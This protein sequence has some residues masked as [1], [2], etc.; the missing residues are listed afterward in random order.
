MPEPRRPRIDFTQQERA[1]ELS[2]LR[3]LKDAKRYANLYPLR[4]KE[5]YDNLAELYK[6]VEQ[7]YRAGR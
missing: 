7:R 1:T 4:L 5:A 2:L 6:L 3:D